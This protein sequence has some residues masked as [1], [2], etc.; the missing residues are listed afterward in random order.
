M[1][2]VWFV[3]GSADFMA[4]TAT[5][6]QW[7]CGELP[8]HEGDERPPFEEGFAHRMRSARE[9]LARNSPGMKLHEFTY[10]N[11]CEGAAFDLGA[12]AVAYLLHD[13][14]QTAL[15]D[16]FYPSLEELGWEGAFQKTFGTSSKDFSTE[17]ARFLEWPLPAQ[18]AVLPTR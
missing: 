7:A 10:Q 14:G 17:F 1:G 9:K 4:E 11:H 13:A 16:T 8:L 15:L 3:E 6:K 2:P 5:R 12:W 18:M